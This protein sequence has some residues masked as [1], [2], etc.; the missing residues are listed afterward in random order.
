MAWQRIGAKPREFPKKDSS[1]TNSY[2]LIGTRLSILAGHADIEGRLRPR[3]ELVPPARRSRRTATARTP[4]RSTC[5]TGSSRSGPAGARLCCATATAS[6]SP[7]RAPRRGCDRRRPGAGVGGD[8]AERLR[9]PD[10]RRSARWTRGLGRRRPRPRTWTFSYVSPPNWATRSSVRPAP[11]PTD[12]AAC[13][14]LVT[15]VTWPR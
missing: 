4:S 15:E 3:P 7:R 2:W 12:M 11:C 5:W 14:P 13:R 10:Y 9:P 1:M 8:L 6:R